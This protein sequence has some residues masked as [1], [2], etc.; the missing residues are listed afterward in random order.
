MGHGGYI[1]SLLTLAPRVTPASSLTLT[2]PRMGTSSCPILG[3]MRSF[4]VS[5]RGGHGERVIGVGFIY[6]RGLLVGRG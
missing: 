2:G 1:V 4:T 5:D 6:V 3:T